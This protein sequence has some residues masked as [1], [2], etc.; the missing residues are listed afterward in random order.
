MIFNRCVNPACLSSSHVAIALLD[1]MYCPRKYPPLEFE[2]AEREEDVA[3]KIGDPEQYSH[4]APPRVARSS[5][6]A[7]PLHRRQR[8]THLSPFPPVAAAEIRHAG[9]TRRI[10]NTRSWSLF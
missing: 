4:G 6:T 5:P 1:K 3:I 9:E 10:L 8:P 7:N 2:V